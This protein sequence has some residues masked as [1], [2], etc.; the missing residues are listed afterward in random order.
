MSIKVLTENGNSLSFVLDEATVS[1]ANAIRR[2]ALGEMPVLAI[3]EV[4]FLDN[5]SSMYDEMLAHRLSLVPIV[6][7][8]DILNLR[9]ECSCEDGCPSCQVELTLKKKGPGN[10][11]SQDLK[12]AN[13]NLAPIPDILIVKLGKNQKVDLKAVAGL[14]SAKDHAKWQSTVIAYK[15]HP[16]IDVS[17]NCN[18]CGDCVSACPIDLFELKG[19]KLKVKDERECILCQA[20]VEACDAGALNVRGDENRFIYKVETTGSLK[21]KEVLTRTCDII[22]KKADELKSQL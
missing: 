9:S 3:E 6:T 19:T 4:E 2:V 20:C 10:V 14:G 7:D 1:V 5:S 13:K 21:P 15:Y 8:L 16:I 22:I 17:K 18:Q 11:H 12:S